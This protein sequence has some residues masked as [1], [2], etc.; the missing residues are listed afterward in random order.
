MPPEEFNRS[1]HA[2]EPPLA[3]GPQKDTVAAVLLRFSS[4][5]TPSAKAQLQRDAELQRAELLN[6]LKQMEQQQQE[7]L[8]ARAAQKNNSSTVPE[9]TGEQP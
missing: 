6:L 4:H 1:L 3:I 5:E 2:F 9:Q 8:A 7:S